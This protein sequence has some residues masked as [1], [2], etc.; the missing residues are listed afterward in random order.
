[1]LALYKGSEEV[2]SIFRKPS[3]PFFSNLGENAGVP[4]IFARHPQRF[5]SVA[6]LAENIMRGESQLSIGERETIAAYVS[7]L[8]ACTY[9]YGSHEAIAN[10]FH[11][12]PDFLQSLSENIETAEIGENFRVIL[13]LVRKLTLTPS[14]MT[15]DDVRAVLDA[16]WQEQTVEDAIAVCCLFNFMNRL[17]DGYGITGSP[18]HFADTAAAI[19]THG[20]TKAVPHTDKNAIHSQ[21]S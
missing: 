20:Y 15:P 1:M 21:P 8:N 2:K 17:V 5:Q 7:S 13:R 12:E 14:K 18:E 19:H 6:N 3:L 9:C 4:D 10:R 11:I 16:G